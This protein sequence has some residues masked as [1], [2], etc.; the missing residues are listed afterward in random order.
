MDTCIFLIASLIPVVI[1]SLSTVYGFMSTVIVR[2]TTWTAFG[3]SDKLSKTRC[4]HKLNWRRCCSFLYL[5]NT[6]LTVFSNRAFFTY[7]SPRQCA[8]WFLNWLRIWFLALPRYAVAIVS[9]SRERVALWRMHRLNTKAAKIQKKKRFQWLQSNVVHEC[10]RVVAFV[11]SETSANELTTDA[12][13]SLYC[14]YYYSFTIP[15]RCAY[16]W[17]QDRLLP[18]MSPEWR[19]TMYLCLVYPTMDLKKFRQIFAW[20]HICVFAFQAI[21]LE[22]FW[23]NLPWFLHPG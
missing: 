11:M 17:K 16:L 5:N 6:T 19:Y 7:D 9:I 8:D 2:V 3:Q 13:P 20:W 10:S 15:D 18:N 12:F 23:Q 4:C 22:S 21:S 14:A 1:L